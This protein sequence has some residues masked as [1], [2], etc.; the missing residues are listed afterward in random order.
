[1]CDK[2]C[3]KTFKQHLL[4]MFCQYLLGKCLLTF[5]NNWFAYLSFKNIL[6]MFS[7]KCFD[8]VFSQ[9]ALVPIFSE[10]LLNVH[11]QTFAS[12]DFGEQQ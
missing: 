7:I 1:M 10:S 12:K 5:H 11:L 8:N 9:M 6:K 4:K 2:Q 3:N